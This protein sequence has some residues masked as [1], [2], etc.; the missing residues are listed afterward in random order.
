M[1]NPMKEALKRA[2]QAEKKDLNLS[3]EATTAQ[4]ATTVASG[5]ANTQTKKKMVKSKGQTRKR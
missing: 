2:M 3:D 4:G 1:A 5:K